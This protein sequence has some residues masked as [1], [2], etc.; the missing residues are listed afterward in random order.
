MQQ[1]RRL[2]REGNLTGA[3]GQ[4][5]NYLRD[6]PADKEARVFL[7]ELLCF[8]GEF[9]RA[10]KHLL[11][12]A[13][14]SNENRLGTAFY[15]AALTAE[16]ERQ[17]WYETPAFAGAESEATGQQDCVEPDSV[18]SGIWNGRPFSGIRDIDPRLGPSL[19][20]LTAGKYHRIE[21]RNLKAIRLDEPKRLRDLY[22]RSANI[23][24][25]E[26][27][28]SESLHG[29]LIPVLYPQS[30]LFDDDQTRLGR[31]TD[32]AISGSGQELPFGQ[33]IL[34]IGD[35]EVPLLDIRSVA[36][37]PPPQWGGTAHV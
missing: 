29:V 1:A 26:E 8:T 15:A 34:L 18:V 25:C 24:L 35:Q 5:Q 16:E 14:D 11:L 27:M 36:F 4:L 31:T 7:F 30:Y 12:L 23:E 28:S 10:R 2:Y 22:W 13:G 3:I 6:S 9:D 20:F 21:F 37:G 32:F 19:E 17:R 33:R